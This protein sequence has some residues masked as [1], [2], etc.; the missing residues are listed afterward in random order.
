VFRQKYHLGATALREVKTPT[1]LVY[2]SR[3]RCRAS[4]ERLEQ[5]LPFR[6]TLQI[7]NAGHF[8]PASRPRLFV[9]ILQQ[10]LHG[11]E[12]SLAAALEHLGP[13]Q[14]EAQMPDAVY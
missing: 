6:S 1:L 12:P 13:E 11:E 9:E 2:G 4:Q 14:A 7:P 8:F 3:S 5:I 10:F